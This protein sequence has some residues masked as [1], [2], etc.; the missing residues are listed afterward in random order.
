MSDLWAR[1]D[2]VLRN[3]IFNTFWMLELEPKILDARGRCRNLKYEFRSGS[4]P[5]GFT[6]PG[7]TPPGSN[8][9]DQED[10]KCTKSWNIKIPLK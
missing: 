2:I 4:T 3:E 10:T 5:P 7:F 1:V 9:P 8:P 6:P